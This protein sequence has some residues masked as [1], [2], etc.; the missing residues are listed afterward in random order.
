M[1]TDQVLASMKKK[2]VTAF[3]HTPVQELGE[4]QDHNCII[5]KYKYVFSSCVL[6][7]GIWHCNYLIKNTM[8]C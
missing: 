6:I 8:I 3:T 2:K 7:C 5:E 1:S 4:T